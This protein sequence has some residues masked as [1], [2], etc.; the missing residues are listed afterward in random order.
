MRLLVE[1]PSSRPRFLQG[2]ARPGPDCE[3]R[4]GGNKHEVQRFSMHRTEVLQL[5]LNPAQRTANSHG[6]AR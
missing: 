4:V 5:L 3:L 1:D 2:H 6:E